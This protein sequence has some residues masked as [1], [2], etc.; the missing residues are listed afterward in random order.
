[1]HGA[2]YTQFSTVV[3]LSMVFQFMNSSMSKKE[4]VKKLNHQMD[5]NEVLL[6]LKYHKM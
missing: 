2:T 4:H 6:C 3:Q 1:M 5:S